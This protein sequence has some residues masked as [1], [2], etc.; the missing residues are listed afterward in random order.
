MLYEDSQLVIKKTL[1]H[2]KADEV[3]RKGFLE[4]IEK[5]TKIGRVVV[6]LD[7]S[8]F[9]H[10]MPRT[11]GYSK[12]GERCYGKR[13]WNARGRTNVIG[14]IIGNQLFTVSLFDYNID[15]DIF[16]AWLT[17]DLVPKLPPKTVV[18][19]DNASFHKRKDI[20][21]ML[22]NSGHV[23]VYLP[24]YSPDLNPIEH[25]WAQA[26]AIRKQKSC[27]VF[28]LFAYNLF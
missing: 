22:Q 12:K 25:K 6:Y 20:Q 1:Y 9:S 4:K 18:I 26:K 21:A 14:A 19:M 24:P 13:N 2:P 10:D 8:G 7:E 27:S 28:D 3:L 16:L 23:L 15:S 5:Y 11:Y 17:K